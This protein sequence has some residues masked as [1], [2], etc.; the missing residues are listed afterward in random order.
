M[1]L[2]A[3]FG[4]PITHSKSPLM[5]NNAFIKLGEN[6]CYNRIR[7]EDG[8]RL[9]ETFLSLGL[10]GANITV[11]H[12]EKA[13][14]QAD[15]VEGIATTIQ[16]VNT[17]IYQEG[18]VIAYNTDAPGFYQSIQSFG[19][20]QSILI[21]GAG[22]TAKA[23]AAICK[24]KGI[25]TT[26]LNR[27]ASRLPFFETLGCTCHT[28]EDFEVH[29]F[30]LVVNTTSAGLKDDSLPAPEET[31]EQILNQSSNAMDAIYGKQTPFLQKAESKGIPNKDGHDMLL[32]QGVI[33]FELFT[34]KRH[35]REQITQFMQQGLSL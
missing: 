22:G 19:T 31:L 14:E 21:L 24:E 32:Y 17:Y 15:Q 5:H 25:K 11:P 7:L 23:V 1:N 30:D 10:Q 18:K 16:A 13:Y 26:V 35:S 2:F 27:S 12:K 33:A 3:I 6:A 8:E 4:D 28:W 20:L 34:Q 9:K 29:P